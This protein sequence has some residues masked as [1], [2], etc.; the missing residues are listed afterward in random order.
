VQIYYPAAK[1][2]SVTANGTAGVS[3]TTLLTLTFDKDIDG[4]APSDITITAVSTGTTGV[5]LSRKAAGT[6]ELAVSGVKAA[7]KITVKAAKNGYRIDPD[8]RDVNVLYIPAVAAPTNPSIKAKF[9]ITATEKTG[10]TQ[11]FTA[12]HDFIHAGGL[13]AQSGVIKTGDWIDLEGGLTVA[14]GTGGFSHDAAAATKAITLD[15]AAHGTLCRLIVVG[16]NSFQ[17][18]KGSNGAYA[19]KTN[20]NTQ[21]VVFQFQNLPVRRRMNSGNT[22]N[23]GYEKSEMRT[24][25]TGNFLTGLNNAGVPDGVLWAPAR[26]LS[27]G[28][29]GTGAVTLS[30]KLWLPTEREIFQ[31]GKS[32][33]SSLLGGTITVGPNS[34]NGETAANQARLEY[35]AS[36]N[37][38]L[39]V[40]TSASGYPNASAPYEW[41]WDGSAY[42]GNSSMFCGVFGNG[43]SDMNGASSSGGVAPAFCVN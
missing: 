37:T 33:T 36:N 34:A 30:D 16:V 31:D 1:L 22:N 28:T 12:L 17:S 14:A 24:Y 43:Y 5:S 40:S 20:D 35:Y 10:V 15:G 9:G 3:A 8:S 38:R 29:N 26:T 7:G 11:T 19:I 4:L 27:K 2:N 42:S 32:I 41:Y 23:D 18:G 21:H 25:L 6:Y 39:K 13:T